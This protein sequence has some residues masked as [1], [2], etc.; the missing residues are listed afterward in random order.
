MALGSA[1][2]TVVAIQNRFRMA[3]KLVERFLDK[4]DRA[5]FK[6]LARRIVR[7]GRRRNAVVHGLWSIRK[8]IPDTVFL[9]NPY[10]RTQAEAEPVF[11]KKEN[12][13]RLILDLE[14]LRA[15]VAKFRMHLTDLAKTQPFPRS[16]L[17]VDE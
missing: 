5:Q 10:P 13:K 14:A 4:P 1:F 16:F 7:M 3:Q 12:F 11:W 6:T 2:V 8:E 9:H 17:I 15:D